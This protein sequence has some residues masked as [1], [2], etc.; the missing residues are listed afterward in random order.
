LKQDRGTVTQDCPTEKSVKQKRI[1]N[2]EL[3]LGLDR[4]HWNTMAV[5]STSIRATSVAFSET[6]LVTIDV[7]SVALTVPG[8]AAAASIT[9]T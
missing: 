2:T 3:V 7:A 8:S 4:S 5:P 6:V 1:W 9:W